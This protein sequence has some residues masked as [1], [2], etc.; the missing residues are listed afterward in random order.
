MWRWIEM[1]MWMWVV[2]CSDC[3]VQMPANY[4]TVHIGEW[5]SR[6]NGTTLT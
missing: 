5:G 4:C 6:L 2:R 3:G 1:W